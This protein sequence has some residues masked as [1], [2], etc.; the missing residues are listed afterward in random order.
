MKEE[1]APGGESLLAVGR[2]LRP[3]GIRGALVVEALTDW[4]ERFAPGAAMLLEAGPGDRRQVNIRAAAE[5]SGKLLVSLEGVEDRNAA[6]ALRGRYLMV[7]SCDAA[8]LAEGEFWAHDLVG[9]QVLDAEDGSL[10]GQVSDVLC[11]DAQD[12]LVVTSQGGV[13]FQVPFVCEFVKSVD[14]E[15][16]V[17]SVSLIEGMGP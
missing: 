10:L 3:H 9:L 17:M 14:V 6:D 12:L 7:R 16:G 11:R 4:P 13:E 15:G 5:H 8:P 2:I 1:Q